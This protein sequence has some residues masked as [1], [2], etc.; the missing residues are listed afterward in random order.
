MGVFDKLANITAS[1]YHTHQEVYGMRT[2]I[3]LNEKLVNEAMRLTQVSTKK[4]VVDL[5]LRELVARH[6]Q[7]DLRA[8]VGRELISPDYDVRAIRKGMNRG[9]G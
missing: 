4:E 6:R 2:N 9:T 1:A 5:A 3:V 7:R 8:L